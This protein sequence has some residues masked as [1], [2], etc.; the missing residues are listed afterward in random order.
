MINVISCIVD[1]NIK[2]K[3]QKS[4]AQIWVGISVHIHEVEVSKR[5]DAYLYLTVSL[6][7]YMVA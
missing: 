4:K 1:Q 7:C 2:T 6:K 5:V 3:R